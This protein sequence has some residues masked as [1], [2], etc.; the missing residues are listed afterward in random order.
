MRVAK[1]F[2][3]RLPYHGWE[4]ETN[5]V[6]TDSITGASRE[7][8]LIA[9]TSIDTFAERG[10]TVSI[11]LFVE[12]KATTTPWVILKESFDTPAD[13]RPLF[14]AFGGSVPRLC[15][16]QKSNQLVEFCKLL[17]RYLDGRLPAT[18][19]AG[20][21]VAEAFR[22]SNDGDVTYVAT[23]QVLS[24]MNHMMADYYD[25][26]ENLAIA[27]FVPIVVTT[28]PLFEAALSP[29]SEY[30]EVKSVA[31]TA[32]LVPN[33]ETYAQV[34]IINETSLESLLDDSQPLHSEIDTFLDIYDRRVL[35][36][37]PAVAP[38]ASYYW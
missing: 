4:V 6:Y 24:F 32:V 22:K 18:P 34:T 23:R 26:V 9:D 36:E 2:K 7:R 37:Q 17:D 14:C 27:F 1:A 3:H 19:S 35:D 28:S 25:G 21:G 8:D 33:K 31:R 16:Q 20:Y 13:A 10:I 5:V 38:S 30:V 12:C 29:S 15:C 11:E